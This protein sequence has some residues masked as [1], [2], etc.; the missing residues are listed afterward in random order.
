MCQLLDSVVLQHAKQIFIKTPQYK[1][2]NK[3][4][5]W[6]VC[7]YQKSN[8]T[9]SFIILEYINIRQVLEKSLISIHYYKPNIK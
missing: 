4:K 3:Y 2:T 6:Y 8:T 1:H 9:V 5:N 7:V